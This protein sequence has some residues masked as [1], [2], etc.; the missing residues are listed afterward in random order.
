[1][2]R[3]WM[4]EIS[5]IWINRT[6]NVCMCGLVDSP[7]VRRQH[8]LEKNVEEFTRTMSDQLADL[9]NKLS[10]ITKSDTVRCIWN[11][12]LILLVWKHIYLQLAYLVLWF[13]SPSSFE[14]FVLL[15]QTSLLMFKFG[16]A[17]RSIPEQNLST[18]SLYAI[19]YV[20]FMHNWQIHMTP[21]V[22][23]KLGTLPWELGLDW[24][25]IWGVTTWVTPSCTHH[26][27][28][29]NKASPPLSR[30]FWDSCVVDVPLI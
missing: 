21:T 20:C 8:Q 22:C 29:L 27:F 2:C 19:N 4:F 11:L 10:C 1:M 18:C 24:K 23:I 25:K 14:D 13:F 16:M 30:K 26:N 17:N 28:T 7:L 9:E 5:A 12:A 3:Q 15:G 6:L